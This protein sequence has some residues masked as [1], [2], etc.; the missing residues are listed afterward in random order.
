M[1]VYRSA[2]IVKTEGL[3]NLYNLQSKIEPG[4][5]PQN[6]RRGL[7]K[8]F[9]LAG[10]PLSDPQEANN[11][12]EQILKP[13]QVRFKNLLGQENF[14]RIYQEENTK[15]EVIDILECF[16]GIAKGSLMSTVQILFDFLAPLL[17]EL[18]VFL[19]LYNN[20]QVIVQPILELF[21]QCAKYMLCYLNQ[22]DSKR[23]YESTLATVQAYA[24]C[25]AN[26]LSTE[27]LQEEN[28]FQDLELIMDLLTFILSKDCLDLSPQI[29]EEDVTVTAADV[30][31]F[32]L[33]FIMPLMSVDLLKYPTLC[34]QYYR[35]IVLI[36]DIYP[37]K[38]CNLPEDLLRQLLQSV[39]LGLTQFGSVIV[40]ACLDFLQGM[41]TYVFRH[42]AQNTHFYRLL[43]PFLRLLLDMML[44]HQI[45]SDMISTAST[46]IFCL[47]CCYQEQY[48]M[49]V[50]GLLSSQSDPL[51]A[52]RLA[53]AFTQLTENIVLN[54]QR[55]SKL[56]FRDNFDKF[57]ANVHGFLLVK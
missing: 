5:L 19:N 31:L 24:K 26:R 40:Q 41:A 49:Y 34:A 9:V 25:N 18:P 38:I 2:Y 52:E 12:Y 56:K 17:S 10:A 29:S 51:I 42:S 57:I 27:A 44:T 39:E 37:E 55:Q 1:F 6:I 3:W 22:F 30:S 7:Y 21:G 13:V 32:G 46:C 11:Y 8:G 35:L 33:N 14:N 45:N 43:M 47:I 54:C 23:L 28:S 15:K 48:N 4:V 53:A 36:N 16:I 50:Q 20:Y